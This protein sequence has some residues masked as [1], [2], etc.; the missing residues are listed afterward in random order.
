MRRSLLNGFAGGN[1]LTRLLSTAQ[2]IAPT[3][4]ATGQDRRS[5][6][7]RLTD[8]SSHADRF[9]LIVMAL[10]ESPSVT[11]DCVIA[12][13]GTLPWQEDQRGNLGSM[14]SFDS[15][16]AIKRIAAGVKAAADR[17]PSPSPSLEGQAATS[18]CSPAKRQPNRRSANTS[19]GSCTSSAVVDHPSDSITVPEAAEL[20][21]SELNIGRL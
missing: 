16:S 19:R 6:P 4:R 20:K 15:G 5:L 21:G 3:V 17:S 13:E 11:D 1:P 7:P 14:L 18:H 2:S 12:A 8:S 9:A 10:A